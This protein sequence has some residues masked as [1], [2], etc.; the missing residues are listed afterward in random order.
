[1]VFSGVLRTLL[2]SFRAPDPPPRPAPLDLE[3]ELSKI[4]GLDSVKAALRN[5]KHEI[6]LDK[7]RRELGFGIDQA[8]AE[9][10]CFM[11]NPGTGK[12][13]IAR[14]VARMLAALGILKKG[15][16]IEVTRKVRLWARWLPAACRLPAV[17][18][19]SA[20]RLPAVCL[21]AACRLPAALRAVMI[22][23]S[24]HHLI[25]RDT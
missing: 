4:V 5:F 11:G 2:G 24:S 15:Q 8:R 1:M 16:L 9:H 25:T 13:T 3:L 12:T 23:Y 7:R 22:T 17:C 20:C 18:L 21:P 14:V 19:P 10:M 6:E